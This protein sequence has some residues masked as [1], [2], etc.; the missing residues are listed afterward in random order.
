MTKMATARSTTRAREVGLRKVVGALKP[1]LIRQFI[2]ESLFI[3]FLALPLALFLAHLFLPLFN[4]MTGKIMK[5]DYFSSP[6]LLPALGIIVLFVGFVSGS[7]PAFFLSAF[8]FVLQ[9]FYRFHQVFHCEFTGTQE[10][11]FRAGFVAEFGLDLVPD[12]GQFFV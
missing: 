2:G 9:L 11:V 6:I 3:S 1:Q 7:Y 10:A 12:L 8:R 4:S 5:I